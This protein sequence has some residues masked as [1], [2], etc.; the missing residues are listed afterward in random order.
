MLNFKINQDFFKEICINKDKSETHCNGK[1]H[2]KKQ[3]QESEK[4][5]SE[6]EKFLLQKELDVFV[7]TYYKIIPN[8]KFTKTNLPIFKNKTI[9][10]GLFIF[11]IFH[12]PQNQV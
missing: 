5:K 1:C 10:K 7:K 4:E 8:P 3:I 6:K 12:P 11:D 9:L 2:L